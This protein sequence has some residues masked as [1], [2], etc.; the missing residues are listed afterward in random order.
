MRIAYRYFRGSIPPITEY[1]CASWSD[2]LVYVKELHTLNFLSTTKECIG[3]VFEKGGDRM[4]HKFKLILSYTTAILTFVVGFA[5][6]VIAPITAVPG[7]A[8][9]VL[10]AAIAFLGATD[11]ASLIYANTNNNNKG[12]IKHG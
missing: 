3:R 11:V 1:P 8:K 6:A 4:S 2:N 10:A 12:G 5:L 9:D 7:E